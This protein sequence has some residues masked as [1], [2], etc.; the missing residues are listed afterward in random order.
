MFTASDIL[1]KINDYLAN[2][3]YDRKPASLYEPINMYC[4][5]AESA[6]VRR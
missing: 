1:E 4:R 6:S 3:P 5:W 2:I